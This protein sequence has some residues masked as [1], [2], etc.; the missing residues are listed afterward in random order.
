MMKHGQKLEKTL[1]CKRNFPDLHG[2]SRLTQVTLVTPSTVIILGLNPSFLR[3]V[4]L[5]CPCPCRNTFQ[6]HLGKNPTEPAFLS[7]PW[8]SSKFE[9]SRGSLFLTPG[10]LSC[11]QLFPCQLSKSPDHSDVTHIQ[12]PARLG[13][14]HQCPTN[15]SH[16]AVWAQHISNP[17]LGPGS[18]LH[19]PKVSDCTQLFRALQKLGNFMQGSCQGLSRHS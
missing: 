2:E 9:K 3:A 6:W 5:Q 8:W 19:C 7:L 12:P 4:W 15:W 11:S 17:A 18:H 16:G 14:P 13:I 1:T 10:S